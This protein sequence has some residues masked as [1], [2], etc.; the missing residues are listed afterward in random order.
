M[1]TYY[2]SHLPMKISL[3]YGITKGDY[4]KDL[5]IIQPYYYGMRGLKKGRFHLEGKPYAHEDW[6]K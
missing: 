3:T 4:E 1:V 2:V 5:E 6:L